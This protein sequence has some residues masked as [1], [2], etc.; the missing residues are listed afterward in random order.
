[1]EEVAAKFAPPPP[2]SSTTTVGALLS[3]AM[4]EGGV[5]RPAILW[6]CSLVIAM[7]YTE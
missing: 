7:Q 4:G 6:A 5:R 3:K 1:M 2:S